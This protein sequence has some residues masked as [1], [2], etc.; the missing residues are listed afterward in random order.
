MYKLSLLKNLLSSD[1]LSTE[2]LMTIEIATKEAKA[3][4]ET[5]AVTAEAKSNKYSR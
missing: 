5:H 3:E 1:F 2:L 4:M